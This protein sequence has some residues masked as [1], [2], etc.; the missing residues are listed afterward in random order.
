ME[1]LPASHHRA[2]SLLAGDF[3]HAR[4]H[5]CTHTLHTYHTTNHPHRPCST[6]LTQ[7]KELYDAGADAAPMVDKK[8][9]VELSSRLR[10]ISAD[11]V[12]AEAEAKPFVTYDS[13]YG[14]DDPDDGMARRAARRKAYW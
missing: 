8:R 6:P 4:T 9:M 14:V 5:T 1:D 7:V 3:A 13:L 12:K 11:P 2:S 10:S